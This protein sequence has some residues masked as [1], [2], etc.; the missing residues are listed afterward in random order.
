MFPIMQLGKLANAPEDARILSIIGDGYH[1]IL[2]F[3]QGT[4]LMAVD[5]VKHLVAVNK[6]LIYQ[7]EKLIT[8]FLSINN[9]IVGSNYQENLMLL[10]KNSPNVQVF[11]QALQDWV[12]E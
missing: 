11:E 7:E 6:M 10:K 9:M 2:L 4:L 12:I 3:K 8:Y 5:D 1:V